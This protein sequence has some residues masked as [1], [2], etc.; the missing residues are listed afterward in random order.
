MRV[1]CRTHDAFQNNSEE[2]HQK[3]VRLRF[4]P[5]PATFGRY[6]NTLWREQYANRSLESSRGRPCF[7]SHVAARCLRRMPTHVPQA[8]FNFS[9]VSSRATGPIYDHR[10]SRYQTLAPLL[11]PRGGVLDSRRRRIKDQLQAW[12]AD[13]THIDSYGPVSCTFVHNDRERLSQTA[14]RTRWA[15]SSSPGPGQLGRPR[16]YLF[17]EHK[18]ASPVRTCRGTGA[19][20]VAQTRPPLPPIGPLGL[21]G[22]S[23]VSVEVEDTSERSPYAKPSS[24]PWRYRVANLGLGEGLVGAAEIG[25][26]GIPTS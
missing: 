17:Y 23:S 6:P 25:E 7:P 3:R 8:F 18:S 10:E 20:T 13:L 5:F 24:C 16:A 9:T 4:C 14:F 2:F 11:G 22:D 19:V 15:S 12:S 21:N 1:P 26:R